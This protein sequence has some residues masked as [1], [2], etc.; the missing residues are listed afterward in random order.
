MPR[1]CSAAGLV[2]ACGPEPFADCDE[3]GSDGPRCLTIVEGVPD[4]LLWA[5]RPAAVRGGLLGSVTAAVAPGL[6]GG[7][8]DGCRVVLRHHGDDGGELHRVGLRGLAA[9][10]ELALTALR[11][12]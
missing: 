5:T 6:F 12:R 2:L 9:G 7:L 8:P 4:F 1:G 10:V 11:S 3:P